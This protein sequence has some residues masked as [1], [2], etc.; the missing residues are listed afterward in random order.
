MHLRLQILKRCCSLTL[1]M[2]AGFCAMAQTG[3]FISLEGSAYG[4]I[5]KDSV[6]IYQFKKQQQNT[7]FTSMGWQLPKNSQLKATLQLPFSNQTVST[8]LPVFFEKEKSQ[9]ATPTQLCVLSDIE[10]NLNA[11]FTLLQVAKVVDSMGNWNFGKGHLVLNGDFVDRGQQVF[12][13]LWYIVL[14]EQ[15]AKNFGRKSTL[16]FRQS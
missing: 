2:I 3:P 9:Y 4:F 11:F 7:V 10:G 1:I 15:Q 13:L 8:A 6:K 12:E 16:H 5:D 14:L